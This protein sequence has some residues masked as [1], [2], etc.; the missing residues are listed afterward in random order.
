MI[1]TIDY[2]E[3]IELIKIKNKKKTEHWRTTADNTKFKC[4]KIKLFHLRLK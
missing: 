2:T 4:R 3:N 1:K